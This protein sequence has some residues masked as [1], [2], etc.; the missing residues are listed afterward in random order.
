MRGAVEPSS[1][2]AATRATPA[3]PDEGLAPHER[4]GRPF[5]LLLLVAW[6]LAALV[7][8]YCARSLDWRFAGW[9][10][11]YW[12]AAQGS[13]LMFLAITVAYAARMNRLDREAGRDIVD[14][15]AG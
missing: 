1:A 3:D 4:L 13:L 6:A 2:A 7:I 8:P 12:M 11:S 15:D 9:S 5:N 10:F 14:L